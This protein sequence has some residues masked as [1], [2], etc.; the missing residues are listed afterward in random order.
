MFRGMDKYLEAPGR[1]RIIKT[2]VIRAF[3]KKHPQARAD[4][5][6][7]IQQTREAAWQTP[8][9]VRRVFAGK[10]ELLPNNR[11]KFRIKNDN[12]RMIFETNYKRQIVFIR[13]L[14]SHQEYD[15]IV[16]EVATIKLY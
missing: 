14:G 7:W 4:L 2:S 1:L 8:A 15:K 11:F 5:E 13:F 6:L 10:A 16:K 3:F 9:E 12:Y